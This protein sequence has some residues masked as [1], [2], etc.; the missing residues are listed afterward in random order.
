MCYE[1][2]FL[3]SQSVR[4]FLEKKLKFSK[5]EVDEL[6]QKLKRDL[7]TLR[8]IIDEWHNVYSSKSEEDEKA[9]R[10]KFD[11]LVNT[12]RKRIKKAKTGSEKMG[13]NPELQGDDNEKES[14]NHKSPTASGNNFRSFSTQL[15]DAFF[16]FQLND[17]SE[18]I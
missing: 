6:F 16:E 13:S 15:R 7:K 12:L 11:E 5:E 10:K 14:R 9:H 3:H 8:G 4:Q 18:V 17:P 2:S 1:S